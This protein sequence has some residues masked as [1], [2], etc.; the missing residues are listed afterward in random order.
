MTASAGGQEAA[1]R[2]PRGC[3]PRMKPSDRSGPLSAG[4]RPR[5]RAIGAGDGRN[6]SPV[7]R[8]LAHPGSLASQALA[9]EVGDQAE[10]PHEHKLTTRPSRSYASSARVQRHLRPSNVPARQSAARR[11]A[12]LE[13]AAEGRAS[14]AST[15]M[16]AARNARVGLGGDREPHVVQPRTFARRSRQYQ[17]LNGTRAD[18]PVRGAEAR[19]HELGGQQR[20]ECLQRRRELSAARGRAVSGR[21]RHAALRCNTRILKSW[22]RSLDIS[23][24]TWLVHAAIGRET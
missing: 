1:A 15:R 18:D 5:R 14:A 8:A 16:P 3:A 21:N 20:V 22:T 10:G 12:S 7:A 2:A 4:R 24:R 9:A 13:T 19:V 11:R 23:Q 17:I 6:G